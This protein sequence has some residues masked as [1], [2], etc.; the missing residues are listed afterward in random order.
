[1]LISEILKKMQIEDCEIINEREF[2]NFSFILPG[3]TETNRCVFIMD[4]RYIKKIDETVNMAITTPELAKAVLDA[5]VGVC[6]TISPR[7]LFYKIHNYLADYEVYAG[8]KKKTVIGKNCVIAPTAVIAE[9]NVI[10][11]DNVVIEHNVIIHENV[12]IGDNSI[13][14]SGVVLGA[15][16]NDYKDLDGVLTRTRQ[17]GWLR[18]GKRVEYDPNG[19]AEKP[20]FPY[21][22]TKVGDDVKIGSLVYIAHGVQIGTRT[23]L[24]SMVNVSGYT[25]IGREC[26]IGPG[27][28][29]SNILNVGDN[30]H[31][32][33]GSVVG[34][35]IY[36]DAHVTGFFA[37][38]HNKFMYNQ[39]QL[40]NPRV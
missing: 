35:N 32:T 33:V 10:I 24:M 7:N 26:F 20:T 15:V 18:I 29:V 25:S 28:T 30:V 13:I 40:L 36:D 21:E 39:L 1:M 11:G 5:G 17:I 9:C 3:R 34:N 22:N 16:G 27:V 31:V 4:K 14:H 38:D 23:R 6:I 8:E 19:C 12:E 2:E 37:I